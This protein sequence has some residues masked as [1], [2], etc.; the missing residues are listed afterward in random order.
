MYEL[1]ARIIASLPPWTATQYWSG[2]KWARA[3]SAREERAD[4]AARRRTHSPTA[5]GRVPLSGLARAMRREAVSSEQISTGSSPWRTV[6]MRAWRWVVTAALTIAASLRS[7]I[8]LKRIVSFASCS[9]ENWRVDGAV[10]GG[11]SGFDSPP[12]PVPTFVL[13][14]AAVVASPPAPDVAPSPAPHVPVL[15][16]P[17]VAAAAAAVM[18]PASSEAALPALVLAP[19]PEA[20]I[21]LPVASA[22]ASLGLPGGVPDPPL[23]V[24]PSSAPAHPPAVQQHNSPPPFAL[25]SRRAG[26][27]GGHGRGHGEWQDAPATIADV[28]QI[29]SE[30]FR[31]SEA[32]P[33]SHGSS[34][35]AAPTPSAPLPAARPA[36][37][38]TPAVSLPASSAPAHGGGAGIPRLQLPS[39]VEELLPPRAEVLEA[40][41]GQLWRLSESLRPLLLVQSLAHGSLPPVPPESL[42]DDPRGDCLDAAD[43][44]A[45]LLAPVLAAPVRGGVG[46]VGQ[47]DAAADAIG[48]AIQVV[49]SV[50]QTMMGILHAL[51]ADCM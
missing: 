29:V 9:G 8:S 44:V 36:V 4:F 51:Q 3:S 11:S 22:A 27:R 35:R 17:A 42:L 28:R 6:L 15:P 14:P 41:L 39:L 23:P 7:R 40:T 1:A 12:I 13:S 48:A 5:M 24:A 50:W 38:P 21:A 26:C 46:A 47:L 19:P 34:R 10:V 25:P 49:R 45:L 18:A 2:R 32:G 37:A 43:Q 20:A 16:S 33:A 31:G 30:A